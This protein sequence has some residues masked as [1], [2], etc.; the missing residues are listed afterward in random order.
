MAMK[1]TNDVLDMDIEEVRN[2]LCR[3]ISDY[4][5][6]IK[7]KGVIIGL[8]GGVDSSTLAALS[9]RAI[10]GQRVTGLMLFERETQRIEDVT[11]ARQ[12]AKKFKLKARN[13]NLTPV[14]EAFNRSTSV[15]NLADKLSN[16]NVKARARMIY[17]YYYA[18]RLKLIVCGSSDKSETMMGYF[19]KWGD[20]A[21]DISPLMDLYKTQVK[22]LA[23]SIGIPKEI[24]EKPS[25][26]M[27]W[28]GQMAEDELGTGYEQL[29]LVLF[30]LERF[31]KTEDI[32][33][34]MGLQKSFVDKI[35]RRWLS[36]EH[37]RRT[38]LTLKLQYRTVGADFRLQRNPL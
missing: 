19:T 6:A 14:L 3:F 4:V 1:L 2:R 34:Q 32:A 15:F 27:L 30:G 35:K 12:V 10:G 8:S 22:S 25:S 18:N 24:I 23:R 26:P 31:M 17:I 9:A 13:V 16:G 5:K 20:I 38:L 36:A 29:D 21:A 33:S 7:A 11:H 28:P 37:K